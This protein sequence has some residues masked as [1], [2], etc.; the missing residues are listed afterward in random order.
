MNQQHLKDYLNLIQHLL[1][2]PD[3][4]EWILL[5]QHEDLV[6]P[7]LVQ[8]MEQ[9][10][11]QLTADGYVDAGKYL[12]NWAAQLHHILIKEVKPLPESDDRAQ[13]YLALIQTLLE[14]PR[15]KV[16]EVLAAHE[17]LIGPGL[18]AMMKQVALQLDTQGEQK[19]AFF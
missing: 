3:G 17:E 15:S 10:A 18:V 6:N 8:V 4:E 19:K 7:E 16:A 14:A 12:H 9:V 11:A 13:T 1:D 2:C 5:Q